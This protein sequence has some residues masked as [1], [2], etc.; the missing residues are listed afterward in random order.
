MFQYG[1][2]IP[3]FKHGKESK[4]KKDN[5]RK[6]TLLPTLQIIQIVTLNRADPW[7][8]EAHMFGSQL[9]AAVPG[10]LCLHTSLLLCET[11]AYQIEG[12]PEVFIAML[13]ARK[14]F[15]SVW[16]QGLFKIYK[17]RIQG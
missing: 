8:L 3:L 9:G 16:I 2:S 14:A 17:L 15:D 5:Y 7:L 11:A 6:L 4:L 1:I 10:C 13:D 12:G